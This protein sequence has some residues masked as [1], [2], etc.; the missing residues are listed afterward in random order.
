M[1]DTQPFVAARNVAERLRAAEMA[2]KGLQIELRE[3]LDG[4]RKSDDLPETCRVYKALDDAYEG[5]DKARKTIYADLE[6][7]SR[8]TIPEMLAEAGVT[9]ITVQIED[10]NYRFGKSQRVSVSMLDKDAGMDWLKANGG[11][12]L[13]KPTVNAAQLSSFAKEF[14]KNRGMD[15][16][17]ETFKTSSMTY[18]SITKAG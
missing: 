7:M 18:T 12:G 1:N 9:N 8:E 13:I 10:L 6:G 4:I 15:L 16:P 5:M 14:L 2:F 11:E 3:A 17:L